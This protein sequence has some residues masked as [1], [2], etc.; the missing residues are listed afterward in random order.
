MISHPPHFPE[1]LARRRGGGLRG[2]GS[3]PRRAGQGRRF[4][5]EGKSWGARP[6][7]VPAPGGVREEPSP[8]LPAPCAPTGTY[9]PRVLASCAHGLRPVSP[10][11]GRG[12]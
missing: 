10:R 2:S 11:R 1:A 5:E 9:R 12:Y 4:S 8:P 6:G 7:G 3:A